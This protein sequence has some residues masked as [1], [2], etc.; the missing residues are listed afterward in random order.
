MQGLW[1]RII[2]E[3]EKTDQRHRYSNGPPK[4]LFTKKLGQ[5]FYQSW[6]KHDL[7]FGPEHQRSSNIISEMKELHSL[8]FSIDSKQI[9]IGHSHQYH[10]R[11]IKVT[12]YTYKNYKYTK[13]YSETFTS[14]L[15]R[16]GDSLHW[17]LYKKYKNYPKKMN[18]H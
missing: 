5:K 18:Q 8:H 13:W 3:K 11:Y 1:H 16:K 10:K 2:R 9:N 4:S 15:V 7:A 6:R 14:V 12:T 17:P